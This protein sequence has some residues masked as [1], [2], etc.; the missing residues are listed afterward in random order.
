[1][2]T[3]PLFLISICL[4]FSGYVPI[5]AQDSEKKFSHTDIQVREID[6]QKALVIKAE[7]P[8]SSIGEKIG[9]MYGM[10]FT[11]LQ[12]QQLAPAGAAFAVYYSWDPNGNSVFEAGVPIAETT[13][14]KDNISY[15]E[16]PVMKV[17][18]TLYTGSYENIGTVYGDIA[19]YMTDNKLESSGPTWEVYLTD[20]SVVKDPSQNQ[21]IIY[22]PIK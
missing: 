20:P 3:N 11:Y 7:V 8:G 17:V 2:K 12:T 21:T 13:T 5:Q 10:L 19:K 6:A 9:E 14:G 15:K 4:F 18:S 16:F 22:F 1:M